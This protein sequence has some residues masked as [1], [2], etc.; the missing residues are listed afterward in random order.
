MYILRQKEFPLFI[1]IPDFLSD[2][3]INQVFKLC[4]E[5]EFVDAT[6]GLKPEKENSHNFLLNHKIVNPDFGIVKRTRESNLKWMQSNEESSWLFEKIIK[7]INEV[8][9]E[10]F[11]FT[12]KFIENLQFTEYTEQSKGFYSKHNDCGDRFDVANFVDIRKLS[13]TIQLSDVSDYEGGELKIY[14]GKKSIYTN[15]EEFVVAKKDKGTI[16]FFPS[17]ATHEVTP[18]TKGNRY[19]L[20]SWAQGPNIL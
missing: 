1:S 2:S 16:I 15:K 4:E 19:S 7:C 20:V 5:I 6:I 14:N 9:A 3:E 8:N 18:V 10:Y 13:F 17:N 12:L 11:G